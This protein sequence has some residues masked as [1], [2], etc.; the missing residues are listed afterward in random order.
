MQEEPER[1]DEARRAEEEEVVQGALL[2][3]EGARAVDEQERCDRQEGQPADDPVLGQQ[4]DQERVRRRV[5]LVERSVLAGA[6]PERQV[7]ARDAE[8]GLERV[9]PDRRRL[10][11]SRAWCAAA[12]VPVRVRCRPF[13]R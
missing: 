5:H 4:L 6:D 8:T 1:P 7:V 2:G 11:R 13:L 3:P 12:C 10:V 9:E